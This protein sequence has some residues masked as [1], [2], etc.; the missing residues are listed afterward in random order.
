MIRQSNA[1]AAALAAAALMVSAADVRAGDPEDAASAAASGADASAKASGAG[2]L[3]PAKMVSSEALASHNAANV[4]ADYKIGAGDQLDINVF[5]IPDLSRS[6]QVDAGGKIVMPLVGEVSAEGQTSDQ[7]ADVIAADL[8]RKYVKNPLVTVVVKD[9]ASERVTIDG[10]VIAPGSYPLT[11]PTTL[12]QAVALARGPD[13]KSADEHKVSLFRMVNGQRQGAV[14]DLA[15][16]R[17]GKA[18]DPA[19]HGRDIVEIPESGG[20]KIWHGF[21]E[22]APALSLF[23]Y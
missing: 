20:K 12:L 16:I 4:G 3:A 15:A 10:A 5:D 8:K 14:Y 22:I 2:N 21:V 9:A 18:V 11:G 23:R 7:L 13:P 1:I 6:L 17:S 19:V